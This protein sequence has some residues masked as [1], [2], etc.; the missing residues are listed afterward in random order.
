MK[1]KQIH[2]KK[3][4]YGIM[5]LV[6][7]VR[8]MGRGAQKINFENRQTNKQKQYFGCDYTSNSSEEKKTGTTF[9]V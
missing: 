3:K 7:Y 4:K 5:R 6:M 9:S 2:E 8:M 1:A